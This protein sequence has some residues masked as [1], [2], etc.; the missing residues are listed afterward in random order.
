MESLGKGYCK[1]G[2]YKGWD[3]KGIISQDACI[4]VCLSEQS[5]TYA[6]FYEGKTCSRYYEQSCVLNDD[7]NHFTFKRKEFKGNISTVI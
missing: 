3:G 7:K 6:A 1:N 2:Y 4:K 5:C